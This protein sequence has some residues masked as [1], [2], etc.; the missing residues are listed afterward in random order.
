MTA[1][2][3]TTIK[4]YFQT[5]DEPNENQFIDLIDSY[6]DANPALNFLATAAAGAA[7]GKYLITTGGGLGFDTTIRTSAGT[8]EFTGNVA[9]SGALTVGGSLS[10]TSL[11]NTPVGNTTPSTGSF[12]TVSANTFRNS[13][14][15]TTSNLN[16]TG[17][18]SA[19]AAFFNATCKAAVLQADSI[20][21]YHALYIKDL[22]DGG[23]YDV[24]RSAPYAY[25]INQVRGI[26]KDG[27]A[28]FLV[29][30]N[31]TTLFTQVFASAVTAISTT[32]SFAAGDTLSVTTSGLAG[33]V[34]GA[35]VF[36]RHTRAL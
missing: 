2:S 6:Q 36:F 14:T 32:M 4:G 15:I 18:T 10:F 35:S 21:D 16:I 1:Q 34:S 26:T 24:V 13:G 9:V 5:G 25:T 22:I 27:N 3:K 28:T 23:D 29:K 11:N 30:K 12:T 8:T 20:T 17:T 31:G 33:A 7:A 19:S